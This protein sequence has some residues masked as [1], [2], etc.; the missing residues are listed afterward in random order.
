[1]WW[2]LADH[3]G[4]IAKLYQGSVMGLFAHL[5]F[6]N[7]QRREVALGAEAPRAQDGRQAGRRAAVAFVSAM[8][9]LAAPAHTQFARSYEVGARTVAFL[10]I[11]LQHGR[12]DPLRNA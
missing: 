5:R 7:S 12:S 4:F 6:S 8:I 10:A 11:H 3:W 9:R 2:D 1:M